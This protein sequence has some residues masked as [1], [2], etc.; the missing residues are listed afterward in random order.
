MT[1]HENNQIDERPTQR[2]FWV[3]ALGAGLLAVAC[4]SA[5]QFAETRDLRQEMANSQTE[6]QELQ[7]VITGK[8]GEIQSTLAE[9]KRQVEAR[10]EQ[11]SSALVKAQAAA[12]KQ[13]KLLAEKLEKQQKASLTAKAEFDAELD[14][15][16]T[17]SSS[18]MNGVKGEVADVKNDVAGVR[19]EVATTKTEIEKTL[20]DLLRVRG[21]MGVMSGLIATNSKEIAALRELGDRSIYEFTLA[22]NGQM[23]RVGDIRVKLKKTDSKRN[24]YTMEILADDKL[25]EKKDRGTN[26]PVQFY[27]VSKA[28]QPYEIVVNDVTKNQVTG[29]L[30]APKL[31]TAKN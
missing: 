10:Q 2:T 13:N 29:Y 23:Q 9:M 14:R 24:R 20:S 21:D 5:Y 19:T 26:E 15:M 31:S 7:K 28:K 30:A 17:E 16:K 3:P 8:D 25:V 11:S 22:K 1:P 27:V 12:S 6:I 4:F 18:L